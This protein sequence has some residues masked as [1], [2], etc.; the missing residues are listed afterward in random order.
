MPL[1][2]RAI[3]VNGGSEFQADFETECQRRDL[4]LFVLPPRCPKLNGWVERAQRTHS[5][6]FHEITDFSLEMV[7]LKQELLAWEHTYNTIRPHQ[8]LG[9]L[10]P[11]QFITHWQ[12][13]LKEAKCH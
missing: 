6:E 13:Q 11:L 5:E 12:R 2:V 4:R 1:P 10:T 3:Q 7:T 8:S 9:Y